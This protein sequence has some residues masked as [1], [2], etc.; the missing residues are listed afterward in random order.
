MQKICVLIPSRY[1][2]SRLPG[3]PLLKIDGL[4]VINRTYQQVKQSKLID[5][6]YVVTDDIRIQSEVEDF[7]GKVL[8]Q[9]DETE[10]GTERCA[11]AVVNNKLE[12]EYYLIVLGDQPYVDTSHIDLLINQYK[13]HGGLYEIYTLHSKLDHDDVD[14]KSIAKVV[15][16]KNSDIMYISRACIPSSKS[17]EINPK[18]SYYKHV[19][20]VMIRSDIMKSYC[21]LENNY[22]QLEED[23]EWL[24]FLYA[25]HKIKSTLVDHVERDMNTPQDY[26]YL[27]TKYER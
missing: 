1:A 14:D 12:Y 10:N 4:S 22:L 9:D 15:L 8:R 27:K 13:I 21:D 6:A 5:E 16:N 25:G 2:S 23:N 17:G 18:I 20:L 3:K 24:K 26:E 7:G 19:S 11:M